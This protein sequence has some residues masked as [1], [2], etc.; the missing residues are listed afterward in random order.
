MKSNSSISSITPQTKAELDISGY[1]S[2]IGDNA[3]GEAVSAD[4]EIK[5]DTLKI[6]SDG[7]N[8]EELVRVK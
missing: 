6:T 8:T 5:G 3:T 7:G 1:A 2:F 4:F